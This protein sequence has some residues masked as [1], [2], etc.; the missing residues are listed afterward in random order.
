[1]MMIPAQVTAKATNTQ[2]GAGRVGGKSQESFA[3]YMDRKLDDAASKKSLLGVKAET[4]APQAV[5]NSKS[6]DVDMADAQNIAALLAQFLQDLQ[7]MAKDSEK[8][9][10]DWSFSLPD[11]Q[12]MEQLAADAGMDDSK[13]AAL[14]QQG[15]EQGNVLNLQNFLATLTR[16]FE[17]RGKGV[18]VTVPETD[19]PFFETIL[20]KLGV[21]VEQIV[22][23]ADQ[24]ATGD[25][26]LDLASFLQGLQE[27]EG[28]GQP[29]VL[30]DWE[31]N[32]LQE[33][34]SKAGVAEELQN[35]LLPKQDVEVPFS[36]S[37]LRDML[38]QGVA[39]VKDSHPKLDLPAFLTDLQQI[40]TDAKFNEKNVGWSPAMQGAISSTY[41]ELL[42]SVDLSTVQ[43]KTV[44]A[45]DKLAI[46][47]EV[48]S[49]RAQAL[50]DDA[51]GEVEIAG[52]DAAEGE[53]DSGETAAGQGKFAA[54]VESTLAGRSQEAHAAAAAAAGR[55]FGSEQQM[56]VGQDRAAINVPPRM[57][58]AHAQQTFHNISNG[59]M[60]G[61]KNNEHHLVLRLYPRE[62][63]EVK[64][65]MT[66][67]EQNVS[68]SFAME[69]H[70]VKETLESNMQQFQDNLAKQGFTLQGCEVSVGQQ[71]EDANA[72]WQNFEQA[73]QNQGQGRV[74]RETLAD[75]PAEAMYIRP[76]HETG[77]EGGISLFI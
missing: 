61:L 26:R 36:L 60:N 29:I 55:H 39:N 70:R 31:K 1:M 43:A 33:I 53:T 7:E 45:A 6:E 72:A 44:Q 35:Q 66:V 68:L 76:V 3:K 49:L 40:F 75:L 64:V 73:R 25:G 46:E 21:P 22:D 54:P 37:R 8:N 27:V 2:A 23:A 50:N 20:S 10:G 52:A 28:N 56:A 30:S 13:L 48:E 63:G 67:R 71:Q 65:E 69:N 19:L 34:F 42:K 77:R 24:G 47:D 14:L 4:G 41:Q 18:D 32:Q 15:G 12:I 57:V 16:H 9:P 5:K 59:V 17:D 74:A 62:L 51:E 38:Q 58:P 11:T